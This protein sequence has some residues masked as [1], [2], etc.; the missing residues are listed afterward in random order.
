[1]KKSTKITIAILLTILSIVAVCGIAVVVGIF[2]GII[3]D[4]SI[5]DAIVTASIYAL[6][7]IT[8]IISVI[9]YSWIIAQVYKS[10]YAW[11]DEKYP[12]PEG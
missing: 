1:M 12:V 7:S 2:E 9:T 5:S 4:I 3:N 11:L 6:I 8:T 10:I